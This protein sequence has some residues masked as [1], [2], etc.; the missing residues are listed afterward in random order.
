MI[1]KVRKAVFPVAGLGTRFIPATKV[2]PKEML[3]IVDKPLIQYVAEDAIKAGITSLIFINGRNK[4]AIEDHFDGAP[5]LE[6]L[7]L[8]KGKHKLLEKI[9]NIVPPNINCINLRQKEPN[10]LGAAIL[11]ARSVVEREPFA[12]VLADD[13]I[14]NGADNS[15]KQ[16]MKYY[17]KYQ[18]NLRR[19][20]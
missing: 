9:H 12:V 6:Q 7:L 20:E 1:K 15:I 17:A 10:G 18:S 11:C 5:Q 14:I 4:R 8:N 13:L 2:N 16:L 3:P 19:V